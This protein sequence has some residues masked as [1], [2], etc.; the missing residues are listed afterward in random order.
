MYGRLA[1][2]V[3]PGFKSM[4]N[5]TALA[6]GIPGSS[7]GKTSGKSQTT[8]MFSKPLQYKTKMFGVFFF[9]LGIHEDII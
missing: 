8:G 2:G 3:V 9:I 6:G 5:S 7:S 1:I 4:T